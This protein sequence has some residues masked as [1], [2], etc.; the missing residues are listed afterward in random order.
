MYLFPPAPVGRNAKGVK[1]Y[2][3]RRAK[4]TT[5]MSLHEEN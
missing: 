4:Q 3:T 5:F 2:S 1:K